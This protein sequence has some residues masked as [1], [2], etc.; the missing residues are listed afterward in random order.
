MLGYF[1]TLPLQCGRHTWEPH[2]SLPI[3]YQFERQKWM[4]ASGGGAGAAATATTS[5]SPSPP[6]FPI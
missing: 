4:G 5:S 1:V 6:P 3:L 2:L